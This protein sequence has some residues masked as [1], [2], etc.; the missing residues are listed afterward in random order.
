[1][2]TFLIV[3]TQTQSNLAVRSSKKSP[4]QETGCGNRGHLKAQNDTKLVTPLIIQDQFGIIHSEPAD[5]PYSPNSFFPWTTSYIKTAVL[6]HS[7]KLK[8]LQQ[9]LSGKLANESTFYTKKKCPAKKAD[10]FFM[11]DEQRPG[12]NADALSLGTILILRK[13]IFRLDPPPSLGKHVLCAENTGYLILKWH[14]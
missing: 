2:F 12:S 6:N 4:G 13:L 10:P 11:M 5:V 1:M 9:W 8:L 7:K 14:L 3:P